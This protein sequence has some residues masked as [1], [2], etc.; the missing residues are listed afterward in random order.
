ML[1]A[2]LTKSAARKTSQYVSVLLN[3]AGASALAA[4]TD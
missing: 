3:H 4:M 2:T 1:D